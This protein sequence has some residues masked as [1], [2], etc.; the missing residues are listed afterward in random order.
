MDHLAPDH[1][2]RVSADYAEFRPGYPDRLFEWLV[3]RAPPGALAWD[4]GCGSG[5][6]SQSLARY[7]ERVHAT[8]PSPAQLS[9]APPHPRI[10]YRLGRES[11]SGLPTASAALVTAAQAAHWFDLGRFYAEADRVLVPGG[12][13]AI[14]CY[15]PPAVDGA[16]GEV[17]DWF[18]TTRVGSCWPPGREHVDDG[19]RQLPFPYDAQ[20]APPL[21]IEADWDL[22]RL[23]GYV[24]SWSAVSRAAAAE[25]SDPVAEL[26]Q[27]LKAVWGEPG[28]SRHL[29]WALSVRAGAKPIASG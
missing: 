13:L 8:D 2:A 26:E 20:P 16:V 7:C 6:A 23:L 19:Y 14:W 10:T 5:Q 4:C 22:P 27:R 1:Y 28:R 9:L 24:R 11:D 29:R 25:G 3:G 21:A 15:G 17:L 18:R 12:L